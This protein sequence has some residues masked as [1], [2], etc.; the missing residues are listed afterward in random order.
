ML[1]SKPLLHKNTA[2]LLRWLPLVF[3]AFCILFYFLM[4]FQAHHMQEKQLLLKQQNVWEGFTSAPQSFDRKVQGEYTIRDEQTLPKQ[5]V[6]EPRDTLI[7]YSNLNKSLPFEALTSNLS[8]NGKLYQVT[9]F[10]SSTEINHLIIKV[11]ITEVI[12]LLLLL[13]TIV[14]LNRKSSGLLWQPFFSTLKKVDKYDIVHNP[15]L[16]LLPET[17]TVEFDHLNKEL[18]KLIS[19]VNTA[20][21]HQKQFAE[22]ASHEMQTPLAIIRSKLELLIN[23]P[24][25]TEKSAA[26]LA[27]ITE[28]NNRLTQ[29]NRTLLLLSKIEN[30]QFPDKE[31]IYVSTLLQQVVN[32]FQNHYE[33]RF[34]PLKIVLQEGV[35]IVASPLL[36]EI[37]FSNL[38][39]NAVEHNQPGGSIT[40]E[41][42][43]NTLSINNT[44]ATP[45][46]DTNELFER[47]KKGSYQS[48][49]TGLGLALV[50][51]ICTLYNYRIRYDYKEGL[52]E[53]EVT[54]S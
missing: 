27:D 5:Y 49:S 33:E 22:N 41:L 45:E 48:K 15:D 39:K 43:G 8:W 2:F 7:F 10:V 14:I 31:T 9:T 52:H 30:N 20:Y 32:D 24:H 46:G 23:Q 1:M 42:N 37:L 34:P 47:F 51:E 29:M 4:R 11:F 26:L 35:T 25:L 16:N 17:G 40:I 38:V 19:R 21:D 13:I 44:G 28:A 36:I 12:I 50:K 53:L 54:F 6:N 18:H 3:S